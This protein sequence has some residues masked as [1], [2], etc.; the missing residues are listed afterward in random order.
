VA[1]WPT[2]I[3]PNPPTEEQKIDWFLDSVTERTYDSIHA[4]CTDKLLEGDLTFAKMLKLYTHKCFQRYPHFQVEDLDKQTDKTLSNNSTTVQRPRTKGDKGKGNP[5]KGR[6]RG[7]GRNPREHQSHPYRSDS[8]SPN[9]G[10]DK[11][12]GKGPRTSSKEKGKGKPNSR[13]QGNRAPNQEPCSYCGGTSHNARN[14][15]KRLA[16]KK[17]TT[18]K[19][20]KQANQNLLIDETTME[21]SQSVLFVNHTEPSPVHRP[22]DLGENEV[23]TDNEAQTINRDNGQ[24]YA[25]EKDTK[26]GEPEQA[27]EETAPTAPSNSELTLNHQSSTEENPLPINGESW[28]NKAEQNEDNKDGESDSGE[29]YEEYLEDPLYYSNKEGKE[30]KQD[31]SHQSELASSEGKGFEPDPDQAIYERKEVRRTNRYKTQNERLQQLF[32]PAQIEQSTVRDDQEEQ[33]SSSNNPRLPSLYMNGGG[34]DK[35]YSKSTPM[36]GKCGKKQTKRTPP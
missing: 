9:K 18:T 29:E 28:Q 15:F 12:A 5:A 31:P 23:T 10:K 2:T 11:G 24:R 36:N 30:T 34:H 17:G 8:T 7:R 19:V 16:D 35:R 6:G 26:E 14:C 3:L 13:T 25:E 22:V 21:F 33:G 4:T 27:N 20:H 32:R 1:K